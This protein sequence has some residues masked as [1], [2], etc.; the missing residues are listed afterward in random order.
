MTL[1]P[2]YEEDWHPAVKKVFSQF[3][4]FELLKI[5]REAESHD[6]EHTRFVPLRYGTR[7]QGEVAIALRESLELIIGEALEKKTGLWQ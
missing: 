6:L 3:K 4:L 7:A 2:W 5:S 1:R